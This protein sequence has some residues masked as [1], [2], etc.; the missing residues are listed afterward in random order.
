MGFA[1]SLKRGAASIFDSEGRKQLGRE[2]ALER[3]EKVESLKEQNR[4]ER[5]KRRKMFEKD[6]SFSVKEFAK[7]KIREKKNNFKINTTER[8]NRDTL[9]DDFRSGASGV[10]RAAAGGA[11]R[12]L[13]DA[14]EARGRIGRF[15]T[16]AGE[17]YT[18]M[19]RR[20]ERR[21]GGNSKAFDVNDFLY[22]S[23]S[24]KPNK[25][26][27]KKDLFDFSDW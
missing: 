19:S 13:N 11:R 12:A 5:Q 20:P 10:G 8:F 23:G 9:A 6:Q 3:Y 15:L 22:G 7:S 16:D 1:D 25:Q 14:P 2:R 21:R 18:G 26:R 24:V 27:G 17:D 4:E